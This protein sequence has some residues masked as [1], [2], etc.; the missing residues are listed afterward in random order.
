MNDKLKKLQNLVSTARET[1]PAI[2]TCVEQGN[3]QVVRVTYPNGSAAKVQYITA[4]SSLDD[5][6]EYLE[7]ITQ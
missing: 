2:G 1:D 5:T 7:W 6:I 3:F 4:P